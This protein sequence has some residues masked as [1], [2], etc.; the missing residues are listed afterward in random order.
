[1]GCPDVT[2]LKALS[3]ILGINMDS[4]LSGNMDL[5]ELNGGNMKHIKFYV[6]PNC[7]NIIHSTGVSEIACCGRKLE[8]LVAKTMDDAHKIT[9]SKVEYDYHITFNHPMEKEHYISFFAYIGID[10]ILFIRMYPEQSSEIRL[11]RMQ[12]G[13]FYFYCTNHELWRYNL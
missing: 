12:G 5:N 2:L 6:C 13:T 3:H 10:R 11:P 8:A 4:I 9:I 7:N 1:M